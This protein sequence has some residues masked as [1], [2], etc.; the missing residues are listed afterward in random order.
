MTVLNIPM[1][2]M[3]GTVIRIVGCS[4]MLY[5]LLKLMKYCKGFNLSVIG[6]IVMLIMS[7]VLLLV[8]V[9]E[10]LFDSL[11]I[12][13]TIITDF[14]KMVIGYIDQGI[15]FL[16]TS[17]L[18]WGMFCIGKETEDK[19][20]MVGAIRNFI[21]ECAYAILYLM[22]FLP[23]SGIQSAQHEFAVI[24]WILYFVCIGLNLFLVFTA[25]ARICDENDVEMDKR[26]ANI[27]FLNGFIEKFEKKAQEAKEEDRQYR[28][29]RR[30]NRGKRKKK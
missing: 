22:S 4:V 25:Y 19:K 28:Q 8:N 29:E 17:A 12:Q 1:L 16:F 30:K 15:T 23:F 21:F 20:I 18:L 7:V 27:P 5:A 6:A 10:L 14:G 24:V 26:T 11:I 3:V 9:D 2:G 13:N